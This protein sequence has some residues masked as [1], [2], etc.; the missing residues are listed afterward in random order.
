M[1][2]LD[3]AIKGCNLTKFMAVMD[4]ILVQDQSLKQAKG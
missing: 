2:E 1:R 4:A 3:E